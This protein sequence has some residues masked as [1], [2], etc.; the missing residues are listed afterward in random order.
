MDV[1]IKKSGPPPTTPPPAPTPAPKPMPPVKTDEPWQLWKDG[2]CLVVDY[3][4]HTKGVLSIDAELVKPGVISGLIDAEHDGG[5]CSAFHAHQLEGD[6]TT[7]RLCECKP[8]K[9]ECMCSNQ[10]LTFIPSCDSSPGSEGSWE[11]R[12]EDGAHLNKNQLF[13]QKDDGRNC[14]M[15]D[16]S[17]CVDVAPWKPPTL[18]PTRRRRGKGSKPQ[19]RRR[20]KK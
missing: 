15:S 6:I 5:Q 19:R 4:H 14:I 3:K 17:Q 12:I 8:P 7:F 20:A 16:E 2:K 18:K 10:A 11:V 1:A 9:N 13:H